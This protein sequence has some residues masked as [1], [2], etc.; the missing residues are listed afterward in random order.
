[1]DKTK[2][3][4]GFSLV[5]LII[6]IS[7]LAI[8]STLWFMSYSWYTKNARDT[9]RVS[10]IQLLKSSILVYSKTNEW[11]FPDFSENTYWNIYLWNLSNKV[12]KQQKINE[13][14]LWKIWISN[15]ILDPLSSTNYVYSISW[16]KRYFQFSSTL[17]K[18]NNLV[19]YDFLINKT[20][21]KY[22]CW[23]MFAYVDWNY[24][25][26]ESNSYPGLVYSF[27][28]ENE[29]LDISSEENISKVVLNN[30]SVNLAY[31]YDWI[32]QIC[33]DNWDLDYQVVVWN[34]FF[35]NSCVNSKWSYIPH[36]TNEV[37]DLTWT[38]LNTQIWWKYK[39]CNNWVMDKNWVNATWNDDYYYSCKDLWLWAIFDSTCHWLWCKSWYSINPWSPWCIQNVAWP[40]LASPQ[41][42]AYQVPVNWS[43]SWYPVKNLSNWNYKV[44]LWTSSNSFE[45]INWV[46]TTQT[47]MQFNGLT[48]WVM[49]FWKVQSCDINWVCNNSNI[50]S[51]TTSSDWSWAGGAWWTWVDWE[52][53]Y[54]PPWIICKV[55]N[56][57]ISYLWC[58]SWTS[59]YNDCKKDNFWTSEKDWN[60]YFWTVKSI[61][62][63]ISNL[64]D[65]IAK[66]KVELWNNITSTENWATT[67]FASEWAINLNWNSIWNNFYWSAWNW[68]LW[69][70]VT[71]YSIS[72][73]TSCYINIFFRA[74]PLIST[75]ESEIANLK[76]INDDKINGSWDDHN[77]VFK[78]K[79]FWYNFSQLTFSMF[80]T[81]YKQAWE[82]TS[83]TTDIN[84][85]DT[86]TL[87][88]TK[89]YWK[90]LVY[91]ISNPNSFDSYFNPKFITDYWNYDIGFVNS[92]AWSDLDFSYPQKNIDIWY[93][94]IWNIYWN[95]W[96]IN[97]ANSCVVYESW[98][99]VLWWSSCSITIF[100]RA[101]QAVSTSKDTIFDL[102]LDYQPVSNLST[103][104]K[105]AV[106]W[107]KSWGNTTLF[108][109][110]FPYSKNGWWMDFSTFQLQEDLKPTW[111]I[112]SN[113]MWWIDMSWQQF[114]STI[115]VYY[116][117]DKRRFK[118]KTYSQNWGWIY[119]NITND[120]NIQTYVD[121]TW[122]FHWWARSENF[123][124][125]SFENWVTQ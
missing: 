21:A 24:I 61:W 91:N 115:K 42:W 15:K 84:D 48:M 19:W 69:N 102:K 58:S 108:T 113:V 10:D 94:W 95:N 112:R 110:Y 38:V 49:Y 30:Q 52:S 60:N 80:S 87:N 8:L 13:K 39:V 100:F 17:E 11:I 44:F 7:I 31:N 47:S 118:W 120:K 56:V 73:K 59:N 70:A 34:W 104:T 79:S 93:N 2:N 50:F 92:S 109:W 33:N 74:D 32:P 111:F 64:S 37:F 27:D 29:D 71:W 123:W 96:D 51:F 36:W 43:I 45:I 62:Y 86:S 114:W 3:K 40:T 119:F 81:K 25:P 18:Q 35:W 76:I 82:P 14:F 105:K 85:F 83:H 63:K 103:L 68:C 78:W 65:W 117:W 26:W 90:A 20:Y 28:Y 99:K 55:D 97:L 101:D 72:A 57:S 122:K 116:D 125:V 75:S 4:K 6:A 107:K 106:Y 98:L 54:C 23:E 5:E 1:M 77:I 22:N 121:A 53:A 66:F 46:T 12:A 41:N 16:D 89:W 88:W 9:K 124:W 67:S